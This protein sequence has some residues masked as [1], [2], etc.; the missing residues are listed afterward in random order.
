MNNNLGGVIVFF[1]PPPSPRANTRNETHVSHTKCW[2]AF[3]ASTVVEEY[4]RADDIPH[5]AFPV[6]GMRLFPDATHHFADGGFGDVVLDDEERFKT[7]DGY[8]G[9]L[10]TL[11][12]CGNKGKWA[13]TFLETNQCI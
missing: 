5:M 2:D 8:F 11:E 1:P 6:A 9:L 4:H 10:R 12:R 3:G 7:V 13:T